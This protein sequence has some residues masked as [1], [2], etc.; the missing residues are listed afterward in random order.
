MR[1]I[2]VLGLLAALCGCSDMSSLLSFDSPDDDRPV[3]VAAAQ[4][5]SA[6]VRDDRFCRSVATQD[7]TDNMLDAATQARIAQQSFA[8][9]EAI[10]G[11]STS[12]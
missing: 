4:P 9:C 12:H 6:P 5:A 1:N 10:F 2:L 3:A 7:A 11:T 8:Q